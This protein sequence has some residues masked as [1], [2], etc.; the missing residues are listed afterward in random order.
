MF[1]YISY[2]ST[3]FFSCYFS[4]IRVRVG[5]RVRVGIRVR[6]RSEVRV[7]WVTVWG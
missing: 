7:R 6:V 4:M 1:I 3:A 5:V 2:L